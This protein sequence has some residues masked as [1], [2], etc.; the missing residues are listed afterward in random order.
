M[1]RAKLIWSAIKDIPHLGFRFF[2]SSTALINSFVGPF[3]PGLVR[4]FG[5]NNIRYFLCTKAR[6]NLSNVDGLNAIAALAIRF[7]W[8]HGEQRPAMRRSQI[9]RFGDRRRE[10]FRMSN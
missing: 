5:E 10:R 4:N 7:G 9:W 2:I 3:G 8:I 1:S 6:W